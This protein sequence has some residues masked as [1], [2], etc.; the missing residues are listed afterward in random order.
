MKLAAFDGNARALKDNAKDLKPNYITEFML[1]RRVPQAAARA[2]LFEALVAALADV[3]GYMHIPYYSIRQQTTYDLLIKW[4]CLAE[5]LKKMA[6]A[7]RFDSIW[8]LL[9][10]FG[11]SIVMRGA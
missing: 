1:V 9:M 10:I 2:K 7:L 8:S 6:S 11:Q 3:E 5:L 4:R